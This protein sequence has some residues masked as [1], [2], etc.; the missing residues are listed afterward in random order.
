MKSK[1]FVE[2]VEEKVKVKKKKEI[3]LMSLEKMVQN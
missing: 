1:S 2:N 3:C